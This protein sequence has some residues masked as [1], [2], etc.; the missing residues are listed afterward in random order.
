M[1]VPTFCLSVFY[2]TF[3]IITFYCYFIKVWI[4]DRWK[5][6]SS[7]T[8]DDLKSN[9]LETC[10]GRVHFPNSEQQYLYPTRSSATGTCNPLSGSGDYFSTFSDLGGP[11]VIALTNRTW[12]TYS[13]PVLGLLFSWSGNFYFLT[14]GLPALGRP[15]AWKIT[16]GASNTYF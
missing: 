15:T 4:H 10:G 1:F 12:W 7:P 13:L 3:L 16:N 5:K 2:F 6:Y 8:K 9:A 11:S 14:F